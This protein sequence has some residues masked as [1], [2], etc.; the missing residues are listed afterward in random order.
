MENLQ[1]TD[2]SIDKKWPEPYEAAELWLK[3][4][5][6]FELKILKNTILQPFL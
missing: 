5:S 3:T 1:K 2:M 4:E 6:R